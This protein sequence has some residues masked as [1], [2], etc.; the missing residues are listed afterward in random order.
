[1]I[2]AGLSGGATAGVC[3]GAVAGFLFFG[4]CIY[5]GF[6]R[7]KR[8]AQGSLLDEIETEHVHGNSRNTFSCILKHLYSTKKTV[9]FGGITPTPWFF[10]NLHINLIIIYRGVWICFL[11]LIIYF[12]GDAGGSGSNLGRSTESGGGGIT[13]DKSVE[14]TYDELSK[15]TDDFNLSNKI[16]QGGFAVVY[17][18]ELRGEVRVFNVHISFHTNIK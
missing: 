17:Y 8:V 9:N 13:V 15:A 4:I 6:Y 12:F 10:F 7:R 5:F 2:E 14:F 1:M 16:G 18:G 11:E 3:V